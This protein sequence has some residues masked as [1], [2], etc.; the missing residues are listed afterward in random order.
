[1]LK[2][3]WYPVSLYCA[4]LRITLRHKHLD[5]EEVP[6]P[7]GYG[8]AE[9]KALVPAGNLPALVD[10]DFLLSDSEAIA[11]YLNESFPEP[12]MLP[13]DIRLRAQA[14]MRGRFHDTRFEPS[15]RAIFPYVAASR[16]EAAV[17]EDLGANVSIQLA[18]VAQVLD[19]NPLPDTMLWL[20]DT[21]FAVTFAWTRLFEERIGLPVTWPKTVLHYEDRL[22]AHEAVAAEMAAYR[23]DM[24]SWMEAKDAT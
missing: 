19:A 12:P 2:I 10:G 5:W 22:A 16:R 3:Y 7:G 24:L 14:R 21:G 20:C 13:G 6:P 15:I 9:Y 17:L 11:E 1:M 8:S 23:P 4:K 18:N